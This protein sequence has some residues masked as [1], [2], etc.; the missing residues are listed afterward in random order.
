MRR[1]LYSQLV[2]VGS[3]VWTEAIDQLQVEALVWASKPS[4]PYVG[5]PSRSGLSLR[6]HQIPRDFPNERRCAENNLARMISEASTVEPCK[7]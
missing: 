7:P 3:S 6:V 2:V 5:A 4:T 1:P